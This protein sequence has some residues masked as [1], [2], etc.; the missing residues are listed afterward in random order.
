MRKV[1]RVLKTPVTLLLLLA[2]LGYGAYWGYHQVTLDTASPETVC[3]VQDV[4]GEL[5]S[6]KV[7]VRVLNGGEQGGAAKTTRFTLLSWGYHIV[8]YNNSD[9]EVDQVTIIGNSA[10][11]PEV[12]LVAQAFKAPVATEG[13]GRV[14]HIVDVILPTRFG[15]V[16]KIP[17]S[18]PVVG[19]V[20]LP[21]ITASATESASPSA[22]ASE[23]PTASTTPTAKSTK[24]K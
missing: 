10:D 14:D 3:V 9:R 5:T 15:M 6:D 12:K 21:P 4:G 1:I 17:T 11:D 19:P 8:S 23:T 22:S 7:S 2:I 13:D 20:C 24:K 18:I 16:D